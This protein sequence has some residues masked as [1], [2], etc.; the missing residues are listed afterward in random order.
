[1]GKPQ[2]YYKVLIK[3]ISSFL[4]IGYLPVAPGTFGSLAGVAIF[5][6]FKNSQLNLLIFTLGLLI[7]GF[8]VSGKAEKVFG[9]NDPSCIVIDEVCGMLLSLLLL[10]YYAVWVVILAFFYF[11]LLDTLKPFPAG[12]V[13]RMSG[14]L[15][16]MGD[17]IVAAFYTNII[18]QI[19]LRLVSFKTS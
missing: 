10:P 14:G 4:F 1:M 12:R 6:L 16:L 5:Y 3:S 17:D 2:D 8:L 9:R 15:G 11:R 13:E 7:L 19:V 18:L